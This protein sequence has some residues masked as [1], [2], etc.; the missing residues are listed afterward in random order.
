MLQP[1][2]RFCFILKRLQCV[3]LPQQYKNTGM[4]VLCTYS[5]CQFQ[6]ISQYQCHCPL[7]KDSITTNCNVFFDKL[8]Y[9]YSLARDTPS[10]YLNFCFHIK[11]NRLLNKAITT[12]QKELSF[13]MEFKHAMKLSLQSMFKYQKSKLNG[14][15][16]LSLLS[17]CKIIIQFSNES[18][19][20]ITYCC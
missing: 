18:I 3:Y 4:C 5:N 16:E 1:I 7:V 12:I 19:S 8:F 9:F 14:A 2:K 10:E 20:I 13:S 15:N 6:C 11:Q 17:D